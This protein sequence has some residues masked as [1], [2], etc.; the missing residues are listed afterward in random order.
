MV[1]KAPLYT[2]DALFLAHVDVKSGTRILGVQTH[3]RLEPTQALGNVLCAG[4]L[5]V[6]MVAA[7]LGCW[8]ILEQP[9]NSLMECHPAFQ[10]HLAMVKTVRATMNM[11]DY[12]G[13]SAKPTW[14]YSSEQCIDQLHKFRPRYIPEQQKIELVEHYIDKSGKPRIKGGALL[15]SSQSYPRPFPRSVGKALVLQSL[16]GDSKFPPS[17]N[18]WFGCYHSGFLHVN[19]RFGVALA[20]LR[21]AHEKAMKQK[22]RTLI[23]TAV[24]KFRAIPRSVR[25]IQ[26]GQT[27]LTCSLFLMPWLEARKNTS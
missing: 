24:Q 9:Q 18:D 2:K 21:S 1:R 13:P 10:Q 16:L 11:G 6:L 5:L 26:N 23:K 4:T 20:K 17:P 15:K 14:L 7:T 25:P 27:G 22:A 19:P 3:D 12:G 8:T